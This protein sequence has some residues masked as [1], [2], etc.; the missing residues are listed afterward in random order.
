M[1]AKYLSENLAGRLSD[2]IG[3]VGQQPPT[4]R[5][6]CLLPVCATTLTCTVVLG[7]PLTPCCLSQNGQDKLKRTIAETFSEFDDE[8]MDYLEEKG[9]DCPKPSNPDV[10]NRSPAH[11]RSVP[12]AATLNIVMPSYLACDK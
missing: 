3:K 11:N 5:T 9:N 4:L 1:A 2:K 6:H 10:K 12:G 8:L 7:N